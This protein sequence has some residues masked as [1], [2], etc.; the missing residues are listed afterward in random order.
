[1]MKSH[2]GLKGNLA[3][4]LTLSALV[5]GVVG[6]TQPAQAA[7]IENTKHNLGTNGTGSNHTTGAT[8]EIC[9]F[10]HT[11]HAADVTTAGA[12]LWN[13][14]LA[15]GASYTMYVPTD[16]LDGEQIADIAGV[17]LPCLSCHD[18]TQAMD[19]IINA[20][21]SGGYTADGGGADGLGW[22]WT[23]ARVDATG[24]LTGIAVLQDGANSLKNDHP[25]GIQYCGGGLSYGAGAVVGTCADADFATPE[26]AVIGTG[27]R[28]WVDTGTSGSRQKTDLFLFNRTFTTAGAGPSVECASCHDVHSETTTFLRIANTGSDLCLTCHTK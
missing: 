25:I 20:P 28:M 4:L 15:T 9:V 3:R 14:R 16:S 27:T 8:T 24:K 13:K 11:P 23:G 6:L 10:C 1:M 2:L 22:T 5:V 18:G 7:S 19:N 21:G 17:S 26:A 12:P